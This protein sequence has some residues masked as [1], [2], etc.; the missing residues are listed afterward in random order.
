[1]R[2]FLIVG[3]AALL[4]GCSAMKDEAA[5]GQ[6]AAHFHQL[7]DAGRYDAIYDASTPELKASSPK[8]NFIRFLDA[9]HRK[10]GA[11]KDAKQVG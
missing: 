7:L 11:V 2:R 10:L 3:A 4:A 6:A 9:V 1:M 5:A 8:P